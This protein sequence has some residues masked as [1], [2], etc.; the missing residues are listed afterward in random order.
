MEDFRRELKARNMNWK[1]TKAQLVSRLEKELEEETAKEEMEK[2]ESPVK[3]AESVVTPEPSPDE[4]QKQVRQLGPISPII[5]CKWHKTRGVLRELQLAGRRDG[6]GQ[7]ME[8]NSNLC[9]LWEAELRHC[10]PGGKS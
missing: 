8:F 6:K 3:E 1:G 4:E 9:G 5:G 2:D 10:L 7:G